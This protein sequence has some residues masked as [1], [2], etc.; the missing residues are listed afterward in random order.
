MPVHMLELWR[1]GCCPYLAPASLWETEDGL[2]IRFEAEGLIH[3]ASYAAAC[4]DGIEGS[5]CTLLEML[6]SAALSF[7]SLQRWLAD[8]AYICLDPGLLFYDRERRS[9]LLT[10]SQQADSRSF[11]TRFAA[12]CRGL[13]SGGILAAERLERFGQSAVTEE[14]RT[15]AFFQQWIRQIRE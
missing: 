14:F 12:C 11:L 1:S 4:P 2:R 13:G 15:A 6:S 8:P 10:F 3:A 7:A 5:F 9:S